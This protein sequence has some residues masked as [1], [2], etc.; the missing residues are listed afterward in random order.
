MDRH[1]FFLSVLAFSCIQNLCAQ[2]ESKWK[3]LS[4][5]QIEKRFDKTLNLDIDF[6]TFS[7]EVEA[8]NGKEIVI[9]GWIIPLEELKGAKYFVLSALPFNNC[10]FCGGAGPET[11][12]EVFC[13]EDIAFT[14]KKIKVKGRLRLN[15]VDPLKLMYSLEEARSVN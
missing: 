2:E 10:F 4:K 5:V 1:L 8:L 6:P 12:M 7:K 9:E 11:V 15:S 3:V 14:E 13:K